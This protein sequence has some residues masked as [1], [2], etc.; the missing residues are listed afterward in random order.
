MSIVNKFA[1]INKQRELMALNRQGTQQQRPESPVGTPPG[2]QVNTIYSPKGTFSGA[3]AKCLAEKKKTAGHLSHKNYK[4][5][6]N[7]TSK[8]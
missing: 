7:H 3:F 8:K 5:R 4:Y 6:Q 2:M 1:I